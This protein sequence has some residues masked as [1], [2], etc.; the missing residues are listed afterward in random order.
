MDSGATG[1]VNEKIYG[2]IIEEAELLEPE[3]IRIRR[4]LHRY[5]ELG[6]MEMRT[7]SIIASYL[8]ECG[9]D[10][11]L[12]GRQVCRE[13]SRMGLPSEEELERHYQEAAFREGADQAYLPDTRGGFT[14]VIG[15]LRCGEGPV[16]AFRFDID[17][18]PILECEEKSHYPTREGFASRVPGVMHACGHDGHTA[19]GLGTAKILCGMREQLHGTVKFIFQPA[20]EGV[21]GAKSIVDQG[22]L[23]GVDYVLGS[24]MGGD[25]E[26]KTAAIGVGN[27]ESMA[28]VKYDVEFHGK[29]AHAAAAPEEGRNA[30][31]AMATAVLNL[32]AIPRNSKGDTRVNVGR[33]TAGSGRNV[34]C[35][36]AHMELEV[37]GMSEEANAFMDAYAGQV[38]RAAAQMHGCSCEIRLMGAAKNSLND[39]A[40]SEQLVKVCAEKLC[41]PVER[42]EK[43]GAGGSEDY[44]Y[45]C[46]RVQRQGGESCYFMNLS[47]CSAGIHSER[48]DFRE[49]ALTN[50]VKAFCGIAVELLR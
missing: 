31:L 49:E 13:E 45:L 3:L 28:T 21:R 18:L 27:G 38:I 42:P 17:A 46:E 22:H 6:W 5:P 8:K 26:Q 34:I 50:G 19:V 24:H 15:I 41:L 29:G 10:Q 37:R 20:E 12:T 25:P 44:S 47:A 43:G 36:H 4:D 40:L 9:C 48:F 1:N 33:V 11:V 7:S 23:D 32:H 39:A 30:M 2:R 35:D 16:V 14:G